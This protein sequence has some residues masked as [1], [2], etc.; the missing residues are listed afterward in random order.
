MADKKPK[1][2]RHK[3][4]HLSSKDREFFTGNLALLLG[5]AVP[6][7]AALASFSDTSKN[8]QLQAAMSQIRR[9]IDDGLSLSQALKLSGIIS[10]QTLA[11]LDLGERS[12]KLV[13]NLEIAAKQEEKQR[14]FRSKVRSAMI[15]PVFV[16]G[17]TLVVAIGVAWFLLPKLGQTFASLHSDIPAITKAMISF[18]ALLQKDG[19]W[20]I[21]SFLASLAAIAYILFA[22]PKTKKIG[23]KLLMHTPGISRLMKEVEVARFGFLLGILLDAGLSITESLK[24]VSHASASPPFRTFWQYLA[25]SCEDGLSFRESLRS[26]PKG[27]KLLPPTVQQM[28]IAGESSG[29]LPEALQHVGRVYESKSD[30]TA[31]NLEAI[32][33]PILLII[34]WFGVLLVG[35]AVILPIYGL[36]GG[37]GQ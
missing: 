33:E 8:K 21:P 24:L 16:M 10:D 6:V 27:Q 28:I 25:E 20:I 31:A 29:S 37:L 15:Y 12:G 35:V 19:S 7:D 22:A 2:A 13:D 36:V 9:D 26:Y 32:I 34:V 3:T 30:A 18:G 11:L 17:I 4:F 14:L 23:H 1:V 5:S